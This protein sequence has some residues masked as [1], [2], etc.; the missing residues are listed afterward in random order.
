MHVNIYLFLSIWRTSWK[1]P[2]PLRLCSAR[3]LALR[4]KAH[5]GVSGWEDL[6]WFLLV[7]PTGLWF[8]RDSWGNRVQHDQSPDSSFLRSGHINLLRSVLPPGFVLYV[9]LVQLLP[10]SLF[11]SGWRSWLVGHFFWGAFSVIPWYSL[12]KFIIP[13]LIDLF[14]S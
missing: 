2:C 7:A 13:C 11:C 3:L 1:C 6:V 10:L 14:F 9:P 8:L 4:R 12:I 5:R